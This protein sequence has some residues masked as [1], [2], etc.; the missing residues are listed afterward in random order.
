MLA[1]KL[2]PNAAMRA[3]DVSRP[4][5]ERIAEAEAAEGGANAGRE[6]PGRESTG[7]AEREGRTERPGSGWRRNG[8]GGNGRGDR[9]GHWERPGGPTGL[10]AAAPGA[11]GRWAA[12]SLVPLRSPEAVNSAAGTQEAGRGGRSP[13]FS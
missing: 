11:A 7:R 12:R 2:T 13:V 1:M 5:A 8:R 10:P 3:R 6:S 4:R 9:E